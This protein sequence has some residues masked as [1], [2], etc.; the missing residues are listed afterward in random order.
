MLGW[1][2]DFVFCVLGCFCW[3]AANSST[4]VYLKYSNC[5]SQ[6][7]KMNR[8]LLSPLLAAGFL[9]ALLVASTGSRV[10][11]YGAS[12]LLYARSFLAVFLDVLSSSAAHGSLAFFPFSPMSPRHPQRIH[13][14]AAD[15][16]TV[17]SSFL[18]RF[19]AHLFL[20]PLTMQ[21]RR[22]SL[23]VR[24]ASLRPCRRASSPSGSTEGRRR[25]A[26]GTTSR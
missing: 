4:P 13:L 25:P 11:A 17:C 5:G 7:R 26:R 24:T 14:R 10:S 15:H 19:S 1:L 21:P 3:L 9:Q 8:F 12:L 16:S 6:Q 23:R 22:S 20:F 18:Y 2:A